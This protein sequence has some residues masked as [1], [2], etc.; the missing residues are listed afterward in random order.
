MKI[1]ITVLLL[2]IGALFSCNKDQLNLLPQTDIDESLAFSTP[3]RILL[4][5]NGMYAAAKGGPASPSIGQ[6]YAG[7]Y[8]VY[9]DIRGEEFINE[10]ANGVTNLQTWNFTLQSSTNEVQ[11]LW[12]AGYQAINRINTVLKGLENAPVSDVLKNQYRGEARF[13]RALMYH[14][15]VNLY[16]RPYTDG[17]GSNPGVIIYTEPQSTLGNNNK[18]RSTVAEVYTLILED[19]N[20]AEANLPLN[21]STTSLNVTRAHRNTAIAY[22]TRI[23]LH[24]GQYADVV[25]EAN[26][27]VSAAGPFVAATGVQHKLEPDVTLV[28]G[29]GGQT[30][31][32]IFSMPFTTNNLPGTQNSL[33]QYYSPGA[34]GGNGD[35]SLN[36]AGAGILANPAWSATDKRRTSFVQVIGT[37]TWLR[38]WT[39]NTDYV[40]VIRYAEVL[41]NL[42]EA[43]ARTNAGVNARALQLVNAVH[44]RSDPATPFSPATQ[45]E[46]I[47]VILTERRIELLGE[48][49]RSMDLT[50]LNAPLPA[51]G[52]VPAIAPTDSQYIWPIPLSEILVNKSVVQNP[53]Y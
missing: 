45:A 51:K 29:A 17:N 33:N 3:E 53:G 49:F 47:N 26:K 38:K 7:R 42:A 1:N 14:S 41:L 4:Q 46:L 10:T 2:L 32:N 52:T 13:L 15:L 39:A 28:F 37:K 43:L 22:K 9:Q 20:F 23:Y 30:L 19:L 21:Y 27:I 25:T 44:Q 35:F 12:N 50:R 16:A 31:E 6:I 8:P 5:V 40:P 24:M 34:A 18:A 36:T 48:G 11:N